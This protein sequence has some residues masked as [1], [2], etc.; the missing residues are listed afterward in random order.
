MDSDKNKCSKCGN[1]LVW[2]EYE[3]K[4]KAFCPCWMQEKES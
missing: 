1:Y 4:L 3:G 2:Q